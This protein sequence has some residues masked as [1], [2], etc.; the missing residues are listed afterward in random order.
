MRNTKIRFNAKDVLVNLIGTDQKLI[1]SLIAALRNNKITLFN[2]DPALEK[3]D[4]FS[5][6]AIIY[7]V[8]G[9]KAR[10]PIF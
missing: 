6:E 10:I 1:P 8:D 9:N 5:A 3:I 2:L 4:L 7:S